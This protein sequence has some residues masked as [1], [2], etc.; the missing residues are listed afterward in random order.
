HVVLPDYAVSILPPPMLE[1][2]G[3]CAWALGHTERLKLG[4]DVLVAPYRH[5]LVTAAT[6]STVARL[7]NGRLVL[8]VGVGYL[9]GEF[10]A[11]GLDPADRGARTDE[12]LALLRAAWEQP[13]PLHH[14]S[15]RFPL[16]GVHVVG[17]PEPR[18][19]DAAVP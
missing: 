2:L 17:P 16:H 12:T 5:P 8:G 18:T 15:E 14:D 19:P 6:A 9:I 4:V 3:A 1:P 11:L 10:E 7:S 13:P